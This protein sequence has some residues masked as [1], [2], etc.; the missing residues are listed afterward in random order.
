MTPYPMKKE[1]MQIFAREMA[2]KDQ[3]IA[4]LKAEV[5]DLESGY[6]PTYPWGRRSKMYDDEIAALQAQLAEHERKEVSY[7]DVTHRLEAKLEAAERVVEAAID[8]IPR[9]TETERVSNT[10]GVQLRCVYCKGHN[11]GEL[12][13]NHK[14]GCIVG[15]SLKLCRDYL[16]AKTEVKL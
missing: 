15:R 12:G 5:N 8:V 7:L 4:A 3:E 6:H 10:Q 16:A 13:T 11:A 9:W 2:V 14:E 1:P